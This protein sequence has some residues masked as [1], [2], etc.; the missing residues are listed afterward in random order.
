M[1]KRILLPTDGSPCSEK[2]L[3]QGL[4]LAKTLGAQATVLYVLE[5]PTAHLPLLPEGVPYEVQLY[6]DLRRSA[7]AALARAKEIADEVGVPVR[8][9]RVEGL[10]VPAIVEAAKAYDLVV[11]GTHGRTGMEKLL[12]GSV[13]DGVLHR[14]RTPVLVVRCA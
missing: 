1:Y 2:A 7:D 13:T 6:E 10:P 3:R 4:E 14:T 5:D 8:T 11:M 12:L 9:E